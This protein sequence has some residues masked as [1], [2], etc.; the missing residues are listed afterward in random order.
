MIVLLSLAQI[1]IHVVILWY[2][3]EL[4]KTGCECTQDIKRDII[5]YIT[6]ALLL[7]NIVMCIALTLNK[8]VPKL[9]GYLV[10]IRNI[11][12]LFNLILSVWYYANLQKKIGCSCSDNWKKHFLLGP[13]ILQV[14]AIIVVSLMITG[15]IKTPPELKK[16]NISKLRLGKHRINS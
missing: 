10:S 9:V 2:I 7:F 13:I 14:F 1:I 4:E 12:S 3:V 8:S 5:K 15:T 16:L 6:L 11:A